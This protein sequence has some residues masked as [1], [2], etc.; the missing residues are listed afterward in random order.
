[1]PSASLS[2][3]EPAIEAE[4]EEEDEGACERGGLGWSW[5]KSAPQ[6][7]QGEMLVVWKTTWTGGRLEGQQVRYWTETCWCCWRARPW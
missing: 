6:A 1:M 5:A 3:W 7:W 2:S 4:E